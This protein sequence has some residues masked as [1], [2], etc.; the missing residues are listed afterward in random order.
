MKTVSELF[1]PVA[2]TINEVNEELDSN[3]EAAND[4]PYERGWMVKIEM[5]DPSQLEVLLS[6]SEY[7]ELVAA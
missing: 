4:D 7:Q 6:S 3:P 2:G 1:A 5:K